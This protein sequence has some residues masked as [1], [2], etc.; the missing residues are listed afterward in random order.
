[1]DR[2]SARSVLI[3]TGR[4]PH[5]SGEIQRIGK[6]ICGGPYRYFAAGDDDAKRKLAEGHAVENAGRHL[7]GLR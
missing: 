4:S 5:S 6:G 7:R 1:M 3:R 2:H